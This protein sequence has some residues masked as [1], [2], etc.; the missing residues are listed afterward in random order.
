VR[1]A[2]ARLVALYQAW[3]KPDQAAQWRARE[4]EPV[5]P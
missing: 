3:G 1:E 4:T 5:K 2:R